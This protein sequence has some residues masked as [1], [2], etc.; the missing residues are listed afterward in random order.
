MNEELIEQYI[1]DESYDRN[2][3]KIFLISIPIGIFEALFIYFYYKFNDWFAIVLFI[4][5]LNMIFGYLINK[6]W[7]IKIKKE[8]KEKIKK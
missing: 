1:K 8:L 7:Y 6:Y 4:T 5:I 2:Y 3:W